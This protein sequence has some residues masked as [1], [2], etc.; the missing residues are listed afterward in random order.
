MRTPH[1]SAPI[2]QSPSGRR[3]VGVTVICLAA[4]GVLAACG[5]SSGAASGSQNQPSAGSSGSAS[6]SSNGSASGPGSR[7]GNFG[8]AASGTI[9][10][11]AGTTMQVQSQQ[12][13]QVAVGWTSSTKF[14]QQ[15]TLTPAGIKSGDCV[16]AIAASGTSST[17][18]TFTATTVSVTQPVNGS[19]AGGFGRGG[20]S[21]NRPS[22][23]PTGE[24]PTNAPS[25]G[26]SQSGFAGGG[27]ARMIAIATGSVVS[28]NGNSMVVAARDFTAAGSTTST[29]AT[30]N[31]T[32]ALG[33]GTKISTTKAATSTAVKVGRCATAEG[34][35]DSTGAVAATRISITEPVNG[36]CSFA[37]GFGGFGRGGGRGNGSGSGAGTAGGGSA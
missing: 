3:R 24:R 12:S 14:T 10:A 33:S 16:T 35:A 15:V 22:G 4:A 6:G 37:G 17:A 28:I 21:G 26:A 13:G 31:K 11:V 34:K 18:T 20:A 36:Q 30:S 9:A 8:P 19:C 23:A 25:P 29:P 7:S 2:L 5:G 27:Q 1:L 32:V